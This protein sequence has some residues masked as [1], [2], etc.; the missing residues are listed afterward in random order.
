[1]SRSWRRDRAEDFAY[2]PGQD[3]AVQVRGDQARAV[4]GEGDAAE[5]VG[6]VSAKDDQVAQRG[7]VPERDAAIFVGGG[8]VLAVGAVGGGED[9]EPALAGGQAVHADLI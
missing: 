9:G 8:Q 2:V 4:R 1:M 7:R 3:R 6:R 5:G